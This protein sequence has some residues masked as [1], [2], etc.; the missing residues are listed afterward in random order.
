MNYDQTKKELKT[1]IKQQVTKHRWID[2]LPKRDSAL[3]II[4]WSK[5]Q[6]NYKQLLES[7]RFST[8]TYYQKI[9]ALFEESWA[10]VGPHPQWF[11]QKDQKNKPPTA[12]QT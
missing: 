11:P 6:D 8:T 5:T 1:K 10:E 2:Q 7:N 9:I 3:Q 4:K 12:T